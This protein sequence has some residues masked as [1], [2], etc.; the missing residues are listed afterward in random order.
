MSLF[1][2]GTD[3]EPNYINDSKFGNPV[4]LQLVCKKS[5]FFYD[6]LKLTSKT[7]SKMSCKESQEPKIIRE[8]KSDC[9][10]GL[11]AD[12]RS[13]AKEKITLVKV[14]WNLYEKF[15]EQVPKLNIDY[16]FHFA[17]RLYSLF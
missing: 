12:G 2:H 8:T 10:K 11:G 13:N 7:L 4:R 15:H 16:S 6:D 17:C 9:S 3:K 5:Q 1:C 14:G